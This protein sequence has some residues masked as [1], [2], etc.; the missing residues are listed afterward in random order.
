M[1]GYLLRRILQAVV[2]LLAVSVIIFGLARLSG[3]PVQ[4][5]MDPESRPEDVERMRE[6]WG[7]DKPL[8]VQYL[9]YMGNVLQGNF[10]E[11][12]LWRRATAGGPG[13]RRRAAPP[14]AGVGSTSAAGA[15]A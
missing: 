7:L 12:L 9:T 14:P 2:S 15:V 6:A 13:G 11:S 1:W 8:P 10:G 4:V 5:M 3:D